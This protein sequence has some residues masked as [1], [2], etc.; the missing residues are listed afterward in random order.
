MSLTTAGVWAANVW[1]STVW[2]QDVWYE[3]NASGG[4]SGPN[5]AGAGHIRRKPRVV[6]VDQPEEEKEP[7]P[8]PQKRLLRMTP[9]V[10]RTIEKYRKKG[11]NPNGLVG[12]KKGIL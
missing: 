4:Y 9:E 8:V 5:G 12:N 3:P 2:A 11:P 6:Y 10:L 1:A 7:E